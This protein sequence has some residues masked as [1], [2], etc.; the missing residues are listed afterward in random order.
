MVKSINPISTNLNSTKAVNVKDGGLMVSCKK[1]EDCHKL[2]KMVDEHLGNKYTI[3]EVSV[4][5]PKFKIVGISG[6]LCDEDLINYLKN[7]NKK[8]VSGDLKIISNVPLNKNKKLYQVVVQCDI[9]TY[10]KMY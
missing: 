4:L 8:E 9:S 3:K 6:K 2:K 1:S 7:Q 5:N 10:K